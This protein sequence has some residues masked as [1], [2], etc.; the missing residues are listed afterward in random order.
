MYRR[1]ANTV[2]FDY[3][4]GTQLSCPGIEMSALP[5][6][7]LAAMASKDAGII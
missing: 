1:S 2:G 6:V 4:P 3:S 7:D 5:R